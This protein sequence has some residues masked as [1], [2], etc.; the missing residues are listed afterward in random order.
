MRQA[1][2][3]LSALG[4]PIGAVSD[5]NRT[6]PPVA[7]SIWA[8]MLRSVVLP[9]P[10]GPMMVRNSPSWTEKLRSRITH[11]GV[12]RPERSPKRLA[13]SLISS[14]GSPISASRLPGEG[15]GR[16]PAQQPALERVHAPIAGEHDA[17]RGGERDEDAWG[18]EI[19]G[20][21]LDQVAEPAVGRDQLGDDGAADG[22]RH[23]DAQARE[24]VRHG[25]GKH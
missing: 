22:V 2:P 14:S 10:D 5:P 16:A 24:D 3:G 6:S 13:R 23:G 8:I 15:G 19:G 9:A 11:D 7:T 1:S 4:S 25:A 20:A 21:E 18:V 12:S 17:G